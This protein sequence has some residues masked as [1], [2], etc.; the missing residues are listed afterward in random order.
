MPVAQR[1]V[2]KRCGGC[3]IVWIATSCCMRTAWSATGA[4]SRGATVCILHHDRAAGV[5]VAGYL[6]SASHSSFRVSASHQAR[7]VHKG[8]G[9]GQGPHAGYEF[10]AWE[11]WWFFLWQDLDFRLW[12]VPDLVVSGFLSRKHF[13]MGLRQWAFATALTPREFGS[14]TLVSAGPCSVGFFS[15]TEF[16]SQTLASGTTRGGLYVNAVQ[17]YTAGSQKKLVCA[18]PLLPPASA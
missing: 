3:P 16:G 10:P 9:G 8:R 1:G 7:V 12:L 11:G 4:S 6:R 2:R 5:P 13:K 18:P 17:L 15:E 14:Q